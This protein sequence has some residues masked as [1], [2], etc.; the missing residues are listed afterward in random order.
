MRA[1]KKQG[2]VENTLGNGK[3]GPGIVKALSRVLTTINLY[4][5]AIPLSQSMCCKLR[6]GT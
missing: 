5:F 2:P 1:I 6:C 4:V 3:S